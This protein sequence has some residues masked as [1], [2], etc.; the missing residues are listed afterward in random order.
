ML[1]AWPCEE[2]KNTSVI[3]AKNDGIRFMHYLVVE[4]IGS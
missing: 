3:K 2:T 4:F 1:A